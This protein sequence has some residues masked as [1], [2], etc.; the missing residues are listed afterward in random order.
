MSAPSAGP[1]TL[2]SGR[3]LVAPTSPTSG[4]AVEWSARTGR[5]AAL[6][7]PPD[8]PGAL[9]TG[10]ALGAL[11]AYADVCVAVIATVMASRGVTA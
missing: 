2:N 4:R 6:A 7:V 3:A 11:A 5:A 8:Q 1:R 9:S 10:T